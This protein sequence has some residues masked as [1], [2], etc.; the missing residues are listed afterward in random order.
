MLDNSGYANYEWLKKGWMIVLE[1]VCIYSETFCLDPKDD[2][3][4]IQTTLKHTTLVEIVLNQESR[5]TTVPNSKSPSMNLF[6]YRTNIWSIDF[7]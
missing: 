1:N 5:P 2:E 7:E 4:N 6:T 3:H